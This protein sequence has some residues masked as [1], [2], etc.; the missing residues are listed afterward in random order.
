[1]DPVIPRLAR[2]RVQKPVVMLAVAWVLVVAASAPIRS[3]A[4]PKLYAVVVGVREFQH[5]DGI[6]P[7]TVSDKDARDFAAFL[8][9]NKNLF[10]EVHISLLVND[11]A[12]RAK[13]V[14]AIRQE[15]KKAGKDD[16]IIIY[17]SGHGIA[18]PEHANEYYFVT[19]DTVS[20][21]LFGTALMVNDKN[22]FKSVRSEKVLLVAD[23]CH[24][25]GFL[26]GIDKGLISKSPEKH[27]SV[28]GSLPGR[29]AISSSKPGEQ[30]LESVQF[31]NSVFTHFLMKGLRGEADRHTKAI[32]RRDGSITVGE[33]FD[34]VSEN[35]SN[36]TK[37]RQNPQLYCVSSTRDDEVIS[38]PT[39][40][41][42]LKIK[43]Q[44]LYDDQAGKIRPL[45]SESVLKSGQRLGVA[46]KPE[47]DCYV[48][49]F[50]W[51]E[52]GSVWKMFPNPKYGDGDGKVLAGKTY[53]LPSRKGQQHWYVLN[54]TPGM[55]TIYFVASRNKNATLD[56][57]YTRLTSLVSD[58]RAGSQGIRLAAELERQINM[59]GPAEFTAPVEG[60]T[61]AVNRE[62]L[63]ENMEN[64]IRVAG[65]DAIFVVR[66]KHE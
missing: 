21:N 17:L 26:Q 30:S 25:G 6:P 63:F 43:V 23:A 7:L 2:I 29:V 58:A 24:S 39:Y 52:T 40:A 11:Q 41:Q 4:W 15:L 36:A 64:T 28:F 45:T 53:W 59:M 44:F 1:M 33:L 56:E 46:F 13:I 48:Y 27:F 35:T 34:Y 32:R 47:T 38:T 20:D 9:E 8:E 10:C 37:G 61:S 66:F 57:L 19:Y 62:K 55:E 14:R 31:G 12:T 51:D 50:W 65:A 49:I 60:S 54:Q 18:H 22:L 5:S 3:A 42:P 16:V